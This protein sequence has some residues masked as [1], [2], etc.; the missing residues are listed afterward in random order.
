MQ[1]KI[2]VLGMPRMGT[3][4][5]CDALEELGFGRMYHMREVPPNEHWSKWVVLLDKKFKT[6]EPIQKQELDALLGSYGGLAD[7]PA[8]IFAEEL[9]E[10]YPDAMIILNSRDDESWVKSMN[11]TLWGSQA[12]IIAGAEDSNVKSSELRGRY[13]W[14]CWANDFPQY[15]LQYWHDYQ[16]KVKDAAKGRPVLNYCSTTDGWQPLCNYLALMFQDLVNFIA[17][18]TSEVF[19]VTSK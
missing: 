14:Y 3:Q 6:K 13:H 18:F 5:I 17:L 15:G 10:L 12:K 8:S 19:L 9:I 2:L 7:F 1:P 11:K 16:R 4:S